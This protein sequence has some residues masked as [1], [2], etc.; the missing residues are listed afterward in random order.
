L[1]VVLA[2]TQ[3]A[4]TTRYV[5]GPMGIHAHKDSANNWEWMVQDGLGSVRGVVDNSVAVLES[6]LYEPCGVP[7]GAT[8]TNQTM[9]GFTGEPTDGN[10]LVHL[11]ARYYA[12]N[13]GA[14]ASRDLFEGVQPLPLTLNG[15]SFV[16]GNPVNWVDP[17]GLQDYPT[18]CL[19]YT[20]I[21]GDTAI[22][23]TQCQFGDIEAVIL[24]EVW[25][26][27]IQEALDSNPSLDLAPLVDIAP[28]ISP[29]APRTPE[30]ELECVRRCP[31]QNVPEST[32]PFGLPGVPGSAEV[33]MLCHLACYNGASDVALLLLLMSREGV[34]FAVTGRQPRNQA[35]GIFLAPYWTRQALV[36]AIQSSDWDLRD[37]A[38]ISPGSGGI[39]VVRQPIGGIVQSRTRAYALAALVEEIHHAGQYYS[40]YP[41]EPPCTQLSP[42]DAERY[43]KEAARDWALNLSG[44]DRTAFSGENFENWPGT[45]QKYST[46]GR[47]YRICP[48]ETTE[49]SIGCLDSTVAK[50][51]KSVIG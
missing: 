17:S 21:Q 22:F 9:Y 24:D 16:R 46:T 39:A 25:E 18:Q 26:Q 38:P 14:F 28:Y 13:L 3:G 50:V 31:T 44:I 42:Y 34:Q 8:G 35:G 20:V 4:N 43:A 6:R 2:E 10:S 36:E 45:L 48:G 12:P 41:A 29:T 51:L 23:V 11:R 47:I 32:D 7:F 37:F 5:H 30:R 33:D 1:S 19:T 49:K 40:Q 15:Y 27:A